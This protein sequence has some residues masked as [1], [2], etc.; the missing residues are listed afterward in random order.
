LVRELIARRKAAPLRSL[1]AAALAVNPDALQPLIPYL[2]VRSA[3]F[4]IDAE[5]MR[6][7]QRQRIQVLARREPG[8]TVEVLRWVR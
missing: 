6:G 8:G 4:R 7:E 3:Y 2:A 1:D 5:A